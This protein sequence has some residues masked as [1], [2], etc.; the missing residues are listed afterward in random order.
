MTQSGNSADIA[1]VNHTVNF[2]PG[3]AVGCNVQL[4]GQTCKLMAR[5]YA[6][7]ITALSHAQ[8]LV[9]DS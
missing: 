2:V 9:C 8:R 7:R 4:D 3:L 1:V 5:Q 6:T